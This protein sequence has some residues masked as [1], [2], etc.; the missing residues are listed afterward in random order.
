MNRSL[1]YRN[2]KWNRHTTLD[3]KTSFIEQICKIIKEL[4]QCRH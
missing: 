3:A 1:H 4:K 2:G